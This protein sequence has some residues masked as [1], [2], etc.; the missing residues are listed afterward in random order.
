M[1]VAPAEMKA[2]KDQNNLTEINN[3]F[4]DAHFKYYSILVKAQ[5]KNYGDEQKISLFAFRVNEHNWKNENSQLLKR[6]DLYQNVPLL[7]A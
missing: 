4:Y 7:S 2:L 6:L 1:S 5:I 3:I